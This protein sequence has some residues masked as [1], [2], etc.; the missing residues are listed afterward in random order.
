MSLHVA[1]FNRA[2]HPE[3][4]ATAQLLTELS[5]D[6]VDRHGCRVS[7][8]AGV[9]AGNGWP[10]R[11][12]AG[13]LVRRE[14]VNGVEVLR[15]PGTR[16]PKERVAG[17]FANYV[18]YFLSACYAGQRLERPDVVV[19]QT[20]PPIIGLAAWLASRRFR[21][22]LVMAYKDVYPE[23]GRLLEDFAS[24]AVERVLEGVNRF[25]VRRARLVVTLGETMRQRLV[26]GK[27]AP[28]ERTVVIEDWADCAAI[29]PGPKRNP[30]A[31]AHGLADRFVVMYSGNLGLAQNLEEVLE[32]AGHLAR[33]PDLEVVLVGDGVKR[34]RLQALASARQLG[35][36]R[37]LPYQ[38][39]ERLAESFATADVFVLPLRPGLAGYIVPSKLYGILAAGRPFVAAVEEACEVAAIAR[40]FDCGRRVE[41]GQPAGLAEEILG[42]YHDR[43]LAARLGANG[44]RAAMEFDRRRQVARYYGAFRQLAGAGQGSGRLP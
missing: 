11:A 13:R 41:P 22:P 38:P 33:V 42:L 19:A 30:F 34:R 31:E 12:G 3:S 32:A 26:E 2:F 8:V 1:F 17:R 40:R 43:A 14:R 25:L 24:P 6:L 27:G 20:D 39:K 9:P 29:V 44:R 16:W 28:P 35:N 18:S 10:G 23:A 37:F 21:A 7:V 15:A 5:Q 4:S 36:V